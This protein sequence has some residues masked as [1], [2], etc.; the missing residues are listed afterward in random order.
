MT[1][2]RPQYKVTGVVEAPFRKIV[3]LLMNVRVG[4]VGPDNGFYLY[5]PAGSPLHLRGGPEECVAGIATDPNGL[6]LF[7]DRTRAMLAVEGQW[8]FRGEVRV[9]PHPK[10]ARVIQEVFN[11]ARVARWM[12]PFVQRGM[13][14]KQRQSAEDLLK[15]IGERLGADSY[16]E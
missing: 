12:V 8:W 5:N 9:E 2:R 10:G 13:A 1:A 4:P 15:R 7:V 16:V 14:A 11:V 6:R 3:D